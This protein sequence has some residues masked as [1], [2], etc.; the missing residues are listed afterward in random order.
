MAT[1]I[2]RLEIC[3]KGRLKDRAPLQIENSTCGNTQTQGGHT[4]LFESGVS[5][6][7]TPREIPSASHNQSA[8]QTSTRRGKV[9]RALKNP[10]A[11]F[12]DMVIH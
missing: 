4:K 12:T 11:A 10:R 1:K 2:I 3:Q 8:A 9:R 7:T 5:A 6:V